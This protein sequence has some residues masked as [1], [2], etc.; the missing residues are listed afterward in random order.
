M[1]KLG[2]LRCFMS[3]R[4]EH[5]GECSHR[6]PTEAVN[7]TIGDTCIILYIEMKSLEVGGTLLMEVSL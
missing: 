1:I 2:P 5:N 6:G 3:T 4:M 7:D